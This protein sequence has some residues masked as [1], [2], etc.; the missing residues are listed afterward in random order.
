MKILVIDL[1]WN[2]EEV[3]LRKFKEVWLK[4]EEE[5]RFLM[6][7]PFFFWF[8]IF[9]SK[10]TDWAWK[11]IA[12]I[13]KATLINQFKMFDSLDNESLKNKNVS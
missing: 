1:L 2:F 11:L 9:S 7:W 10:G 5:N 3:R 8:L 6:K 4:N 12:Y 13:A